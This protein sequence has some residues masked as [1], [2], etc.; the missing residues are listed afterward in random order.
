MA[1]ELTYAA[2]LSDPMGKHLDR[3]YRCEL[4]ILNLINNYFGTKTTK[5][6][7]DAFY[8]E[9][10]LKMFGKRGIPYFVF[11]VDFEV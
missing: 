4:I 3:G 1:K 7:W 5:E 9:M 8:E 11:T 2:L 6:E 10:I